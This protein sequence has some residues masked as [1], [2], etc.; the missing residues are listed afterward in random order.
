MLPA[1]LCYQGQ[2]T[3]Q[4]MLA[5][6]EDKEKLHLEGGNLGIVL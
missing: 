5:V 4:G 2:K 6:V 3:V 1:R